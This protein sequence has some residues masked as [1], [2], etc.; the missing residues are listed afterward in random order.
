MAISILS[1]PN[2]M[3]KVFFTHIYNRSSKPNGEVMNPDS[4]DAWRK[5]KKCNGYSSGSL[6]DAHHEIEAV[7]KSVNKNSTNEGT[8]KSTSAS[9][10]N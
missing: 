9:A 1:L 8:H 2:K 3:N 4:T 7:T 6:T 10:T 5:W